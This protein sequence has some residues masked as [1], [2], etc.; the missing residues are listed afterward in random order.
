MELREKSRK[1]FAGLAGSYELTLDLATF[2]QDRL[3]KDWV[4]E[5]IGAPPGRLVLDIGCGT[6]VLEDRMKNLGARFVG[7]D[8]SQEMLSIARTKDASSVELLANADAEFLPFTD[9]S[10]DSVVSCYVPKYV[11]AAMFARELARVTRPGADVLLYDFAR[12]EGPLAPFLLA[13]I[14]AGLRA[15]GLGLR[16][17]GRPESTT[18]RELPGIIDTTRWDTELPLALRRCGFEQV[19]TARFAGGVLFAYWGKR[20]RDNISQERHLR[21]KNG[22]VG[23]A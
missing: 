15:I 4:A 12:P 16:L 5:R 3:W 23:R 19:E 1:I 20:G 18:F 13:Y 10:F 14:M 11:G 2:Y 21:T 9:G 6:L 8:L 17:A 22:E 7:L